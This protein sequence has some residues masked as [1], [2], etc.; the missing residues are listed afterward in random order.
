MSSAS[1]EKKWSAARSGPRTSS[2]CELSVSYEGYSEDIQ[3]RPPDISARGMFINTTRIFPEGAVLN[4]RF[5]L[6]HTGA[7]VQTRCEVRYCHAGIGIGV[8]FIGISPADV[9]SI[10]KE[11]QLGTAGVANRK[12]SDTN[13]VRS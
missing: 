12:S 10:E 7:E 1:D 8:E 3:T 11:I 9:E 13:K 6:A 5:R 4:V 2:L